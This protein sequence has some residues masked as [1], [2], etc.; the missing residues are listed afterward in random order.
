[1][2]KLLPY[3]KPKEHH[4]Y[5]AFFLTLACNL[6]CSY[7]INIHGAGSRY[8]NSKKSH[9]T[10]KEW[11]KASNRLILRDDLPLTLQGGEPTLYK[12]F[13]D[14][15]NEVKK[16]VKMDLLTNMSFDVDMF[17]KNTPV[18][19]FTRDAPYAAIR[20]SYHPDQNNIND[21]IKKTLKMQEAGFRVGLYG[22]LVPDEKRRNHI[23]EVQDM[24]LKMGID[25]R[26]KEF[27]GVYNGELYGTFKYENSV[28]GDQ[29]GDCECK[30]TELIV[31]P[32][33]YVY[34]CHADL[35]NGRNPIAHILDENF[36]EEEI[37][38][39][40]NCSF[41]G[42]C[43]PCDVK[44]KTNRFQNFGHTSVEIRNILVSK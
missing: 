6:R 14:I 25:F 13:Y 44:V 26:T 19:R 22:I 16:E 42:E 27:L 11:V 8:A 31:D 40:R 18:W 3:I 20:A 2:I 1:M 4:N 23:L 35:Y 43:N 37:D 7:C 28:C 10:V 29:I 17:I 34:G 36:N 41:Y 24:C 21:L 32:G 12:G 30:P 5:V 15:V 9:L 39:F 33:G 38:T